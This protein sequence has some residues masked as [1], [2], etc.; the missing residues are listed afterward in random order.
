MTRPEGQRRLADRLPQDDR[1]LAALR[2]EL[3]AQVG[4]EVEN[5]RSLVVALADST[6]RKYLFWLKA[7]LAWCAENG[8]Q[9]TL[10]TLTDKLAAE[11]VVGLTQREK[12]YDP[13]SI[14]QALAALRYWA[15]RAAVDPT[16]SFRA[17]F[18]VVHAYA[19][20]LVTKGFVVAGGRRAARPT[21]DERGG[22]GHVGEHTTERRRS[23]GQTE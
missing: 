19:S 13:R 7:Y 5:R 11:F 21:V 6:R 8:Y 2:D 3:R 4:A 15:D 17:A 10:A 16:P 14:K 9:P 22:Q 18:D 23:L 20:V 12:P 1:E